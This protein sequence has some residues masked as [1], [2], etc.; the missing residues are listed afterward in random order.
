MLTDTFKKNQPNH[1]LAVQSV[2]EHLYEANSNEQIEVHTRSGYRIIIGR[3]NS[4]SDK[5]VITNSTKN[6]ETE[7]G[8]FLEIVPTQNSISISTPTDLHIKAKHIDIQ[9]TEGMRLESGS[10][11][12]INGSLVKIN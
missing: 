7:Q 3:T 2:R 9:A 6:E 8:P 11:V 5:I 12:T 10:V 4:G 1:Q